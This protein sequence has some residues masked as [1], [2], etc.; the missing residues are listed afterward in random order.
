M[1]RSGI[2][3]CSEQSR[4]DAARADQ[5]KRLPPWSCYP[6]SGAARR[7]CVGW[8]GAACHRRDSQCRPSAD[9]AARGKQ[10]TRACRQ[11]KQQHLRHGCRRPTRSRGAPRQR[12]DLHWKSRS[13]AATYCVT[14]TD[15]DFR[16]SCPRFSWPLPTGRASALRSAAQASIAHKRPLRTRPSPGPRIQAA[17]A[18]ECHRNR[19]RIR[20][21]SWHAL[22][23]GAEKKGAVSGTSTLQGPRAR[24]VAPDARSPR[25]WQLWHAFW[26]NKQARLPTPTMV[27]CWPTST[28]FSLL[29][30]AAA[31]RSACPCWA[32]HGASSSPA[33]RC[34]APP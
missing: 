23:E 1:K 10:P 13:P 30:S 7:G 32:L 18:H 21:S 28:R 34:L 9:V 26:P 29:S 5:H 17:G 3:N 12:E 15:R 8:Q 2:G 6:R 11:A 20:L 4:P 27:M 25:F 14:D 22:P 31:S 16:Q 33:L 24:L 19:R